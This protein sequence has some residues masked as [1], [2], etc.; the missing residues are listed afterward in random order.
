MG[1]IV[2]LFQVW[3]KPNHVRPDQRHAGE[4]QHGKGGLQD[5]EEDQRAHPRRP[6]QPVHVPAAQRHRGARHKALQCQR[7]GRAGRLRG[8]TGLRDRLPT[9]LRNSRPRGPDQE[10]CQCERC[11]RGKRVENDGEALSGCRAR[12]GACLWHHHQRAPQ[13]SNPTHGGFN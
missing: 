6:V 2:C 3:G 10:D 12:C 7:R 8:A 11:H 9:G 5:P 4:H 13:P 1:L